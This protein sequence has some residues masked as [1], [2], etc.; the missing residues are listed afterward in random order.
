LP[1][2]CSVSVVN[3]IELV[4]PTVNGKDNKE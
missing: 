4:V 3:M 2:L 1:E